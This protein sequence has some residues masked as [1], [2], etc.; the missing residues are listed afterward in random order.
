MQPPA[1]TSTGTGKKTKGG[2]AGRALD[3]SLLYPPDEEKNSTP[4]LPGGKGL[5]KKSRCL[6]LRRWREPG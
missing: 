5:V 1:R 2:C 4:R 3:R 6:V